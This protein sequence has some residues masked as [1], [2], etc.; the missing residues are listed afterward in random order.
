LLAHHPLGGG[1]LA[2]PGQEQFLGQS[3]QG[4]QVAGGLDGPV[5]ALQ[6]KLL[7]EAEGKRFGHGGRRDG[8][9]GPLTS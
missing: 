2:V 8:S 4:L 3:L 5:H 1:F 6:L 7:A 9:S